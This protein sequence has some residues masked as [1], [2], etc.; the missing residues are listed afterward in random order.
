MVEGPAEVYYARRPTP[1]Q[2]RPLI[3]ENQRPRLE[4][5]SEATTFVE[6]SWM[7]HEN[8]P[9]RSDPRLKI[10]PKPSRELVLPSVEDCLPNA[11]DQQVLVGNAYQAM[12]TSEP[13]KGTREPVQQL[14]S[15]VMYIDSYEEAPHTKRRKMDKP[16]V[17]GSERQTNMGFSHDK[18][19]YHDSH[20]GRAAN[21]NHHDDVAPYDLD[22]RIVQLPPREAR[23]HS[24]PER[25]SQVLPENPIVNNHLV[26]RL[27]SGQSK[28]DHLPPRVSGQSQSLT[29][30]AAF[31]P[32]HEPDSFISSH[33]SAP[34][35]REVAT[36]PY[37]PHHATVYEHSGPTKPAL[38]RNRLSPRRSEDMR[39]E[40]PRYFRHLAI[41]PG[42]DGNY[43]VDR[44]GD[45]K[46]ERRRRDSFQAP[47]LT[48][49]PERSDG[50][51]Y[52]K[53]V[54]ERW[55]GPAR[56]EDMTLGSMRQQQP[57]SKHNQRGIEQNAA[58]IAQYAPQQIERDRVRSFELESSYDRSRVANWFAT[59]QKMR[60]FNLTN[61][62]TRD[63][64]TRS[65]VLPPDAGASNSLPDD[66]YGTRNG[67]K[68]NTR[69]FTQ[70]YNDVNAR[71][72][73]PP[74]EIVI[75]D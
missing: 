27:P 50:D 54:K 14:A 12:D 6:N 35:Y 37:P 49:L 23:D 64:N 41:D 74:G 45:M 36:V 29:S 26:E 9:A 20:H 11:K 48:Y 53:G 18:E 3:Y 19:E 15:R 47:G 62:K 16:Y 22:K 21:V 1:R 59:L 56:D 4:N 75:L 2:Y 34:E 60:S 44:N 10:Q 55:Y 70:V 69:P 61:T 40:M 7:H 24:N 13:S 32:V 43:S 51:M 52:T 25:Y 63:R 8:E 46:D 39:E 68:E 58:M 67:G 65:W 73:R 72:R 30:S 42:A 17:W 33:V 57:V 71:I 28:V 5:V 31:Y 38:Q 66:R